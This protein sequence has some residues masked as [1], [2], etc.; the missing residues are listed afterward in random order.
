[1]STGKRFMS[2]VFVAIVFLFLGN[3]WRIAQE[4][5]IK[6]RAYQ[7]GKLAMIEGIRHEIPKGYVFYI[8]DLKFVPRRDGAVNV[9][10]P[11]IAMKIAGAG[12]QHRETL[13][14]NGD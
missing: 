6:A 8:G 1:M 5:N 13:G 4:S 14:D 7:A 10:F 9:S 12:D 2:Y 11:P 3:F